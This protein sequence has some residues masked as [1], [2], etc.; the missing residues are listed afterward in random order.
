ME[1]NSEQKCRSGKTRYRRYVKFL[2]FLR[3]GYIEQKKRRKM[4]YIVKTNINFTHTKMHGSAATTATT[5]SV[6]YVLMPMFKR[7][8]TV[9]ARN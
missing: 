2:N 9:H 7:V 1:E 3:K 8:H 5:A 6:R 4:I